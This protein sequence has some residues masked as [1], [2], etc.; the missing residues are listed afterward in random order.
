MMREMRR[1]REPVAR[2][3][4][5]RATIMRGEGAAFMAGGDIS[6]F[7]EH[8]QASRTDCQLGS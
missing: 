3:A 4:S 6:V 5:V 7:N 8:G 1:I 2:D